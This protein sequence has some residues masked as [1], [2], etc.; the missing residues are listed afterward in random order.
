MRKPRPHGGLLA[1]L[2]QNPASTFCLASIS[3]YELQAGT[4]RTRY[5]D[6]AKALELHAWITDIQETTTVLPFGAAEARLTALLMQKRAPE[7]LQDAMIA[8][9]AITNRLSIATRNTRDFTQ[10]NVP[11]INPFNGSSSRS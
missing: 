1:W 8:A 4:E 5:Q 6:P 11:L 7:L 9:T 10:F 2:R 3:L